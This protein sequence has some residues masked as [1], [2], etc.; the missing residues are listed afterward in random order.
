MVP[1]LRL[2][3]IALLLIGGCSSAVA[4]TEVTGST[5]PCTVADARFSGDPLPGDNL[6]PEARNLPGNIIE[7]TVTCAES[8]MSD[9][10]LSGAAQTDF[11]CEYSMRNGAVVADCVGDKVVTNDGG[12]WVEKGCTFTITDTGLPAN[13]TVRQAGVLVGTGDYE[14]LQFSYR[15]EGHE[16]AYPWTISGTIQARPE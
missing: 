2:L 1:H 13:G 8:E 10:R 4:P 3:P 11:R 9:E 12:T 14:G 15:M 16:H 5:G 6:P 7:A